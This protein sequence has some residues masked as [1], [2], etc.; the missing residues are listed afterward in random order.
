MP[1]PRSSRSGRGYRPIAWNAAMRAWRRYGHE[2]G[3][4][5]PCVWELQEHQPT[6]AP[7]GA[8]RRVGRP[9]RRRGATAGA[10]RLGQI[11]VDGDDVYWLEGRASEGGRNVLVRASRRQ[12]RRWTSRRRPSTSA[13]ACT[14]TAARP[15]PCTRAR[16]TPPT[17]PTSSSTRSPPGAPPKALTPAGLLLCAVPRGRRAPA[18]AVRARGPH[19]GRRPAAGGD[20]GGAARRRRA[21]GRAWC[22]RRAPTSIPIRAQSRRPSTRVA[23]VEPSATCRGTAPSSTSPT[24]TR[25]AC[26]SAPVRVAG[27]AD[28]SVFQPAWSPDGVLYFVS[29]RT[30]WWNLYRQRGRRRPSR[31][32]RCRP[33]SA[34]RSGASA[35]RPTPSRRRR[36]HRRHL[37]RE[38]PLAHGAAGARAATVRAARPH[39]RSA[40][41]GRG[42][43]RAP[44]TSWAARPPRGRPSRA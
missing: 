42:R 3:R 31:C 33:T 8:L 13:A 4:P 23:A 7:T 26:R 38:R 19:E 9:S 34:S 28:E 35:R 29:D 22:W 17:S 44:P 40:R 20:R 37:R 11:V 41:C 15:T 36:P 25:A 1:M 10:L 27:G 24:S 39:A 2:P 21:V 6:P 5:S 14:S 12:R 32:T 16:S 43:R 30:G 18:P